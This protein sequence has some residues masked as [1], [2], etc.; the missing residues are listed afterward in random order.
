MSTMAIKQRT[1]AGLL[2]AIFVIPT[3]AFAD[4]QGR[5]IGKI[6]DPD[7]N[8]IKG[9]VVT[10]TSPDLPKF[11]EIKSTNSR[12]LFTVKFDTIDVTYR[13]R[14]D[15][16]GFQSM[17][18]EQ[19]WQKVGS[20]VYEWTMHPGRSAAGGSANLAPVSASEPAIEAFNAGVTAYKAKDYATAVAKFKESIGHD[21]KLRQAWEGMATA[22]LSLGHD[23]EAAEAAEKAIA[24]GSTDQPVLMARWQAYRDLK[25]DAKAAA[26]LQDLQK[27]GQQTEEAKKIHNEGVTL[28]N[29]KD[30][31]GA[32]AQFQDALKL[33]PNLVE[34]QVGLAT[35]AY[36]SGHYAEAATAAEAVLKANPKDEA[37]IRLRYNACLKLGDTKKLA[38]A[39]VALAAVDPARARD[40]LLALAFKAYDANDNALA[41]QRF[42]KVL[43]IDPNQPS[44]H[45]YVA[46]LDVGEG[47]TEDAK[48]HLERFLQLA[49]NDKDAESARDMLKYLNKK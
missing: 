47:K 41:M 7:G 24:L 36:E 43:E 21:P 46:I 42:T 25:E 2:F 20:Q 37:A 48:R 29:A 10:I 12:G 38:D 1:L 17:Q 16:P 28:L 3:L 19:T 35:A 39:L 26:A 8:P 13:Y 15:K 44:A 6:S 23:K 31:E 9:V 5:L 18:L 14:F 11:K 49:P 30:Y 27:A 32:M 40:G 34:A 45:Y 22:E 33:D 4:D